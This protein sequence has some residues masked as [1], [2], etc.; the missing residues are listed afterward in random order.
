MLT[1]YTVEEFGKFVLTATS[2]TLLGTYE[3]YVRA[4]LR[5]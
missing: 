5:M 3:Y 2:W 1:A 4:V